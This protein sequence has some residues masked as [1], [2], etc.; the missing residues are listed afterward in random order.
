M[1]RPVFFVRI[2]KNNLCVTH[3]NLVVWLRRS[4]NNPELKFSLNQAS[5]TQP[6]PKSCMLCFAQTLII[7]Y[8]RLCI[9]N[10]RKQPLARADSLHLRCSLC[11]DLIDDLC[12]LCAEVELPYGVVSL[13]VTFPFTFLLLAAPSSAARVQQSYAVTTMPQLP[14]LSGIQL[15]Y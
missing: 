3:P 1:S 6:L 5:V 10:G 2:F 12:V 9:Y 15:H 7:S 4:R 13:Q 11:S 14:N 8:E